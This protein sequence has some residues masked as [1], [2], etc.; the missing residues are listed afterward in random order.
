MVVVFAGSKTTGLDRDI[1]TSLTGFGEF[2]DKA[3]DGTDI[4]IQ[5][6]TF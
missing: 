3:S 2:M 1:S 5:L 4:V 6:C